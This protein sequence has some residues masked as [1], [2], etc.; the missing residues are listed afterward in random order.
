MY[1][2]A[3]IRKRKTA[4]GWFFAPLPVGRLSG[5]HRIRV[6]YLVIWHTQTMCRISAICAYP[7]PY[8]ICVVFSCVQCTMLLIINHIH[9]L[10]M[11]PL[12]DRICGV[13]QAHIQSMRAR[14]SIPF[15]S[16]L[17]KRK[18]FLQL[19]HD[20]IVSS[21]CCIWIYVNIYAFVL[22]QNRRHKRRRWWWYGFNELMPTELSYGRLS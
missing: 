17:D 7:V 13:P 22:L 11:S 21:L 2:R 9:I 4:P 8:V 12:T 6:M 16:I 1:R 5:V 3:L 18:H 20:G 10:F 19:A 14:I 15:H